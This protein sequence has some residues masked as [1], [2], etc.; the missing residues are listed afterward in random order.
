MSH[1]PTPWAVKMR[2][3][4]LCDIYD[5]GT[6]CVCDNLDAP[7]ATLIV[8]RVNTY[9]AL[10]EALKSARQSLATA[11]IAGAPDFFTQDDVG[12][13]RVVGMIDAALA[14]AKGE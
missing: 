12:E 3:N 10:V 14:L 7:I 1:S 9:D 5:A 2:P 4:G 13:H 8:H 11:V 6:A